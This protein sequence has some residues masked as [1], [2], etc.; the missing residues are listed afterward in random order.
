MGPWPWRGSNK[1]VR[2]IAHGIPLPRVWMSFPHP[3]RSGAEVIFM[4]RLAG[5]SLEY[6]WD[7]LSDE[8]KDIVAE[9]LERYIS[10][11]RTLPPPSG[12]RI[13]Y[14]V[15]GGRIRCFRLH[16][17]ATTGPFR[18]EEYMNLQLRHLQPLAD[19][20]IPE[21]VRK[22]HST[23]HPLA[24][25]IY[26]D[27]FPRNIMVDEES[28]KVVAVLDWESAGWFPSHWEYCKCVRGKYKKIGE[29][30]TYRASYRSTRKRRKQIEP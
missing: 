24:I 10:R 8:K 17:D 27:F 13:I 1:A 21:I 29:Q 5:A 7:H 30:S 20:R 26:N 22:M 15:M 11:L 6:A 19:S 25:F 23:Q 14:S 4:D 18:D 2:Y 16:A 12:L 3:F 9:R 28:A